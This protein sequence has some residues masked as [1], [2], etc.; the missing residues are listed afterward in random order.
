[1]STVPPRNVWIA[2]QALAALQAADGPMTAKEV[3]AAIGL[4]VE[5]TITRGALT[6]LARA[7]QITRSVGAQRLITWRAKPSVVP[8]PVAMMPPL[9]VI[10][11][12]ARRPTNG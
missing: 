6:R 12:S 4:S 10:E 8:L 1:M 3:A 7:G 9:V 5:A 11:Q 2:D